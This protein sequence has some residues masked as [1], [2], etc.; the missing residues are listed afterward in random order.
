MA[1]LTAPNIDWGGPE[2]QSQGSLVPSANLMP[3]S[4]SPIYTGGILSAPAAN[5][6]VPPAPTPDAGLFVWQKSAVDGAGNILTDARVDVRFAET[7]G[8][9][10][11]FAD[12]DGVT[13]KQ[14]PFLVDS[15]G[16]AQFYAA[17]GLYNIKIG[18]ASCRERV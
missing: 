16:F 8:V 10:E 3:A 14:N 15:E 18:R 11:I 17:A 9:A 4:S 2:P 1:N 6:L 13:R 12:R 7:N 5:Q